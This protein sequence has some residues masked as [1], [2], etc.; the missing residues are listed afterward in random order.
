[1]AESDK[2]QNLINQI[3]GM[4]REIM[5]SNGQIAKDFFVSSFDKK[6]FE[7]IDFESWPDDKV[8]DKVGTLMDR[9][10]SL[11]SSIE[12]QDVTDTSVTISSN[13][14]YGAFVNNG[15]S[16]IP[17]RKFIGD[18]KALETKIIANITDKLNTII[19]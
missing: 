6:G 14:S 15:T 5:Q 2:I 7:D 9:T 10:G 8:D 18:S 17:A 13:S 1:M 3:T 4:E 12:I 19:K 16:R 11:K